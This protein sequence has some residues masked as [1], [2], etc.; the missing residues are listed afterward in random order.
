MK[1]KDKA[2]ELVKKFKD[3]VNPYIGS[4]M[5]SNTFDNDAILWQS[6]KCALIC[7]DNIIDSSPTKPLTGGY[8]E[9]YS[10]MVYEAI[11]FW[12]RVKSFVENLTIDDIA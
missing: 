11:F 2:I 7:I 12:E 1:E 6:K 4:G 9:L 10:D 5:L 8:I 3:H